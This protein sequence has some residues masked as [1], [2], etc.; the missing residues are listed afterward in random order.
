MLCRGFYL[1]LQRGT[2]WVATGEVKATAAV[3]AD[4]PTEAAT[5]VVALEGHPKQTP[6]APKK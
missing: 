5:S 1:T 4:F 2:E 6:P 3:P